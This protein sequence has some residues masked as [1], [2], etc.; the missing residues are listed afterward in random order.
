MIAVLGGMLALHLLAPTG[1]A[2]LSPQGR[3]ALEEGMAAY[4]RRDFEAASA[5]FARGYEVDGAAVFLY[6]RAQ[7]ARYLGDCDLA[8]ELYD[9]YLETDPEPAQ[10][11]AALEYRDKCE[12][13]PPQPK[14]VAPPPARAAGSQ[15]AA[16]PTATVPPAVDEPEPRVRPGDAVVLALGVAA[17]TAGVVLVSLAGH[18]AS[19]QPGIDGYEAFRD[20]DR[21]KRVFLGAGVPLATIGIVAVTVSAVRVHRARRRRATARATRSGAR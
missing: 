14:V 13:S 8:V 2:E 21:D 1:S 4:E 12:P 7:A 9:A 20:L 3:E 5:L 15:P 19:S 6:T 11:E 10:R 16:R 17:A 18:A